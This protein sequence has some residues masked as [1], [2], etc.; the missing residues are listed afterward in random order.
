MSFQGFYTTKGLTLA[1]KLA[2]GTKLTITKVT[3]GS[4]ETAKSAAA[5]AQEQQTLTAGTAAISGESAV[6]PVTLAET[7]VTAAYSLTEL[8]VYAQDPDAGEILYQVFRLDKPI[9]LTAGGEDA[10]RFYLKQTVGAAG[11]T[12]TCS[13]AG[14]LV[15]EDLQPLRAAVFAKNPGDKSV[16]LAPTELFDYIKALPRMLTD[17]LTITLTAGTVMKA[18]DLTGFYGGGRLTIQAA[19]GADV[20]FA[21]SLYVNHCKSVF[22]TGL[23]FMG[24]RVYNN[25][26]VVAYNSCVYLINCTLDAA[27]DSEA[28]GFIATDGS[29]AW[30]YGGSIT[31]CGVGVQAVGASVVSVYD[32]SAS[33]NTVGASV[34]S[35]GIILLCGS[36]PELLGGASN[37]KEGGLIV[38]ANGT[39]L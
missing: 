9:S 35:G 6:L 31:N 37:T 2:A 21:E 34:W 36:T 18:I 28:K 23:K 15:D 10:C 3:A 13:P 5:L 4:G 26:H 7:S 39:L 20:Q 29:R 19:E 25:G 14:L 8:G 38:K 1:A 17:N 16:T 11:I 33:G 24:G 12:V 22:L 27:N 30:L 32:I